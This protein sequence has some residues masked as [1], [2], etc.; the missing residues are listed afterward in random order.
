MI[1]GSGY[2]TTPQKRAYGTPIYNIT[3]IDRNIHHNRSLKNKTKNTT[4]IYH[5]DFSLF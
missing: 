3:P 2:S 5:N 1:N 4:F